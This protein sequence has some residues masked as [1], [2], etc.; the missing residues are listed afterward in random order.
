VLASI[1]LVDELWSGVAVTGAPSVEHELSLSHT[2]YVTLAFAAPLLVAAVLEGGIALFS[3]V[4]DRRKLVVGGQAALAGSLLFLAWSRSAW[5]L[6][7]GLALAGTSSGVA[8]GAAQALM[9]AEDPRGTDRA[10]LRWTLFA[11]VGDV[12]T[13]LVTG[14]A[15]ALGFSYRGAMLVI[16]GVVIL[17]CLGLLRAGAHRVHSA[18]PPDDSEPPA[19]P[20]RAALSRAIRRPRLWAWLFAA[21]SCTLLDELVVALAALRMQHD[22]RVSE[23]WA[24]ASAVA[25]SA[26]AILGAALTDR[27]VERLRTLARERSQTP[28]RVSVRAVLIVSSMLCALALA[29][30]LA[31]QSAIGSGVALFVVGITCAPHHAL[32]QARA[33]EELPGHPGTVQA[34][35]QLF[36]LVD[37]VAPVA[38][39]SLADHAGLRAA[40]ACLALQPV[41]IAACAVCC[42]KRGRPEDART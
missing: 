18:E 5:A 15:L 27:L 25:F 11:A 23:A 6:A 3:D 24:A 38:L 12:L 13:P 22:Q 28:T 40:L 42:E 9:L 17:Q 39:G 20:L 8:C 16:A 31:S 2:Q 36:V 4:A 33:Y 41:I 32:A 26:G 19:D 30:V 10:M 29:G 37:V 14:G 21:A 34:L 35:S 1:T 7:F